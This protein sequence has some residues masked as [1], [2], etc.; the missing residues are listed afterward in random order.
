MKTK[1][2]IIVITIFGCRPPEVTAD[3]KGEQ[4]IHK[5]EVNVIMNKKD[6]KQNNTISIKYVSY[7]RK[8]PFVDLASDD[9]HPVN[10][11]NWD[12]VSQNMIKNNESKK[13][14]K[15]LKK[16]LISKYVHDGMP[17]SYSIF[18]NLYGPCKT[19][20]ENVGCQPIVYII[21]AKDNISLTTSGEKLHNIEKH[22]DSFSSIEL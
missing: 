8:L 17:F 13:S 20:G 16:E 7:I 21:S 10:D 9:N 11:I 1:Y 12:W 18:I 19:C 2:L 4:K 14:P 22:G 15:E 3:Q 5:T 6:N